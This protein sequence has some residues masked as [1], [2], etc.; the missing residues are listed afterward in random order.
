MVIWCLEPFRSVLLDG[1]PYRSRYH[2]TS[3][4][5]HWKPKKYFSLFWHSLLFTLLR[6]LG[7]STE[8]VKKPSIRFFSNKF[9]KNSSKTIDHIKKNLLTNSIVKNNFSLWFMGFWDLFRKIGKNYQK[10]Q[11]WLKKWETFF[12][13]NILSP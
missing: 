4:S 12:Q 5:K 2:T 11:F 8:G 7:A 1:F 3:R 13:Q 10:W 9:S 6:T